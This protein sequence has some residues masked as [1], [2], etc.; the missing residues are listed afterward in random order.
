MKNPVLFKYAPLI[1]KNIKDP[2]KEGNLRERTSIFR[3]LAIVT[4]DEDISHIIVSSTDLCTS[5]KALK[6]PGTIFSGGGLP[7]I[8]SSGNCLFAKALDY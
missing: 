7:M 2:S 5:I 8:F 3:F 6:L 1:G 4:N